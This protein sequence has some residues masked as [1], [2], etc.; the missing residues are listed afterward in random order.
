MPTDWVP[1]DVSGRWIVGRIANTGQ[2]FVASPDISVTI[3]ALGDTG[4]GMRIAAN[5]TWLASRNGGTAEGSA[6]LVGQRLTV[7]HS[8]ERFVNGA[9]VVGTRGSQL[10]VRTI[11]PTDSVGVMSCALAPPDPTDVSVSAPVAWGS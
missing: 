9:D 5:G 6:A 8:T 3:S 7:A 10:A 11:M 4:G 2:G 1:T